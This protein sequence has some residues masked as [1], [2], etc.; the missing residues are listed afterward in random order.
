MQTPLGYGDD[1]P[2]SYQSA[3]AFWADNDGKPD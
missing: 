2:W 1:Q 3:P